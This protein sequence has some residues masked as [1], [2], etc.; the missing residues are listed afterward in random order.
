MQTLSKEKSDLCFKHLDVKAMKRFELFYKKVNERSEFLAGYRKSYEAPDDALGIEVEYFHPTITY[1]DRMR[2]ICENLVANNKISKTNKVANIVISHFYGAR[3]IHQVLTGK[4]DPFEAYVDFDLLAK[5]QQKSVLTKKP[6]EYSYWLRQHCFEQH[7]KKQPFWGTT[8]L[9]TSLQGAA[10]KFVSSLYGE[11]IKAPSN[12][13]EWIG[14]WINDGT[15]DKILSVNSMKELYDVFSTVSGVGPYYAYHGAASGSNNFDVNVYHDERFCEPGP[16]AKETAINLFPELS[17]KAVTLSERVIWIRENQTQIMDVPVIHKSRHNITVN[18]KHI[19][20]DPQ[21][22]LKTYGTEVGM[23]QFSVYERLRANPH[24]I[25][26]RKV[27]R[28]KLETNVCSL[29]DFMR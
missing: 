16:G 20:P 21:D 17:Q 14:S 7:K 10:G 22:E 15:V 11:K 29:E 2:Y 8:E 27:S 13:A 28:A 18:D 23:C 26:K 24:L 5:E 4:Q 9:H 1:D 19:Y 6:G 12:L 25:S 3:G